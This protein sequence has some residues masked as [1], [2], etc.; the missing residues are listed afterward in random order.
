M[1]V[2]I[3]NGHVQEYPDTLNMVGRSG[4]TGFSIQVNLMDMEFTKKKI[5]NLKIALQQLKDNENLPPT[6]R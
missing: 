6:V 1:E 4:M 5:E 2:K 3:N